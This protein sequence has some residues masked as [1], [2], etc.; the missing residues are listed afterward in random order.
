MTTATPTAPVDVEQLI[1]DLTAEAR[2][3]ADASSAKI[4]ALTKQLNELAEKH[5][6]VLGDL[7][8]RARQYSLPGSESA[9][10]K[11]EKYSFLKVANACRN[12]NPELAPLE[13]EMSKQLR[14]KAMTFGTDSAGGFLV[15]NEVMVSEM[16]PLLRAESVLSQMGARELGLEG[17]APVQIP[18][19]TTGTTGY[20]INGEGST[21]TSADMVFAQLTLS[22]KILAALTGVSDLL[23]Q[24]GPDVEQMVREDFAETLALKRDLAGLSGSGTSGEPEGLLTNASIPTVSVSD[25]ATYDQ[26]LAMISKVR[27]NNGLKGSLGWVMSNDDMLEIEQMKDVSSG[28]TNTSF[29]QLP[30]RQLLSPDGTKLLGYPAKVSTQLTDGDIIF[31][32]F[33]DVILARWGGMRIEM[34]NAVGFATA[35]NHIRALMYTDIGIRSVNSFCVPA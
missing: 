32:N 13:W 5:N 21:I 34:T 23:S 3:G 18:R 20:W 8:Q 17:K 15:P 14:Q 12:N 31:G 11:G 2:R 10:H 22:P 16:I 28:G 6:K 19:K 25:P 29:Q 26:L 30:R 4:D 9:T 1:K 7:E 33:A 27:G 35:T 24:V